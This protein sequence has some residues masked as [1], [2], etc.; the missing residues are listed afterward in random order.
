MAIAL[1]RM[2]P[3]QAAARLTREAGEEWAGE[4]LRELEK[5]LR[6]SPLE[7]FLATWDLPA[8]GVARVFGVSRQA[9]AKWRTHG[10]PEDRQVALA[11]L[12]AATDVLERYVR[13][14]R[15]PAVVRRQ[16]D[17]LGG[18]SLLELA[19][20]GRTDE[21]RRQTAAMFDLRR[22]SP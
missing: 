17:L 14:D 22:I 5:R 2:R 4:L 21:V 18:A 19:E 7:R 1:E 13:R 16:A 10:V 6:V 3:A 11:D 12:A 15:I 20:S 8:A 9:V